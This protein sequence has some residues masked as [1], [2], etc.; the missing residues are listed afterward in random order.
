MHYPAIKK[1]CGGAG[2]RKTFEIGV[3]E[4]LDLGVDISSVFSWDE[5]FCRNAG[6][7]G[8]RLLG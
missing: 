3:A 5:K 1:F 6:L 7:W 2:Y 4:E 8:G